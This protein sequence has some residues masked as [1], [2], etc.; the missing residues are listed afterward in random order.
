MWLVSIL[1]EEHPSRQEILD[2]VMSN[3][4]VRVAI[5]HRTRYGAVLIGVWRVDRW[6]L[7]TLY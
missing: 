6:H 4:L 5:H 2:R 3:V 1:G 7:K